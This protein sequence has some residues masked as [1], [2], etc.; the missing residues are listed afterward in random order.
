MFYGVVNGNGDINCS[1]NVIRGVRP[2]VSLQSG[3][4]VADNNTGTGA[5]SSSAWT[6]T[7]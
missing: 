4:K 5:S 7:K 3:V 2:V 6:I 1:Y